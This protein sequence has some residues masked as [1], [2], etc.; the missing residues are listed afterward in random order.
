LLLTGIFTAA[1]E[2]SRD[3]LVRR[4]IY[5]IAGEHSDLLST[6]GRAELNKMV[7]KKVSGVLYKMKGEIDAPLRHELEESDYKRFIEDALGELQSSKKN[8]DKSNPM[9]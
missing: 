8:T 7:E 5:K 3:V 4:E 9:G 2:M 1:K 6:I